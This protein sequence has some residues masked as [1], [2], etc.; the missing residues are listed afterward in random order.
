MSSKSDSIVVIEEPSDTLDD[1]V[2]PTPNDY[3]PEEN[4][5]NENDSESWAKI[6]KVE[7]WLE[8]IESVVV[9]P[10]STKTL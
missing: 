1:W 2:L 8:Q 5:E 4:E 9:V 6:D 3:V 7:N 10:E